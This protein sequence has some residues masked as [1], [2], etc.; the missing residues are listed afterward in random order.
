MRI[1]IS[2]GGTG[3]HLFPG[4]AVAQEVLH[5]VSRSEVLF[6]STDRQT[7]KR[8][9]ADVDFKS[10]PL[11]SKGIKGK[12]LIDRL[13]ALLQLPLSLVAA[14]KI[15]GDFKPEVVLGVGG[16]VTGP[17]LLAAWLRGVPTCIHEQN[18]LPGLANRILSKFVTRVYV[19]LPGTEKHFPRNKTIH[20]GNPVRQEVK[21]LRS[22]EKKQG[23]FTL[24]VMGGSLG[25]HAI[26]QA[27][28]EAV[29]VLKKRVPLGF[30][31]IH[32]T[33]NEDEE[34]VR[35]AY[36]D[37]GLTATVSPFIHEM[38]MAMAKADL[39]VGRAGATSLAELTVMGKPMI[40]IPYPHAADN[41]QEL[42]GAML[43]QGGA[44]RMIRESELSGIGLA[45]E[46]LALVQ[47]DDKRQKMA[48]MA[49]K[50]GEPDAAQKIVSQCLALAAAHKTSLE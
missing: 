30:S 32:Q 45:E 9:L 44:A 35:E 47:S 3:G 17:M 13:V 29:Q 15:I 37:G 33:G 11:N 7:D 50:F 16:Y 23:G 19:S 39:V 34:K 1:L 10:M 8:V 14:L 46:I 48:D 26:N 42:N 20:T 27:M 31:I 4:I 6:V 18:S 12:S 5:S 28:I 49:L 43:V 2:G 41:H 38:P 40:L 36:A 22:G 24:L 21:S 25:A